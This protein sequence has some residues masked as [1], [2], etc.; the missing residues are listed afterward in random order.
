MQE[1]QSLSCEQ[2]LNLDESSFPT[3]T[4]SR[5]TAK[6]VIETCSR[7]ISVEL[8][9]SADADQATLMPMESA[10]G[11]AWRPIAILYGK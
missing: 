6:A 8:K 11:T 2:V 3:R 1:V 5:A 10:D 9:W 4:A 7:S